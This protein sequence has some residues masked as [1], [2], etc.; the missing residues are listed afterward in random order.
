M[1]FGLSC[2]ADLV[3]PSHSWVLLPN[4]P[5]WVT[6]RL[7]MSRNSVPEFSLILNLVRFGS[8]Q[9]PHLE[10][11]LS[12]FIFDDG[13][14]GEIAFSLRRPLRGSPPGSSRCVSSL[15]LSPECDRYASCS[16]QHRSHCVIPESTPHRWVAILSSSGAAATHSNRTC[17]S[18]CLSIPSPQ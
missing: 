10:S 11:S 14:R 12:L 8:T 2:P 15:S 7:I 16:T 13:R 5:P 4:P 17:R 1:A 9:P 18:A 6:H 3:P